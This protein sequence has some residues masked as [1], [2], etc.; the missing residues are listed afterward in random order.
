MRTHCLIKAGIGI[1]IL[2]GAC[3]AAASALSAGQ[4]RQRWMQQAGNVDPFAGKPNR[5]PAGL[6]ATAAAE[7]GSLA[8]A[9]NSGDEAS[10][11]AI[12]SAAPSNKKESS[13]GKKKH[14]G[15]K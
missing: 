13:D 12:A 8:G 1:N 9:D 4:K 6:P 15:S 3:G 11:A 14:R 2:T 10:A 5:L 7:A